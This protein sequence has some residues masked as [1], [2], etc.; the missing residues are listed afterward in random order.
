MI[1]VDVALPRG[2]SLTEPVNEDTVWRQGRGCLV[3]LSLFDGELA[4]QKVHLF[5]HLDY[6]TYAKAE[7][8][9]AQRVSKS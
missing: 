6:C 1:C 9:R 5:R 2:T 8:E 3:E 4:T 7:N